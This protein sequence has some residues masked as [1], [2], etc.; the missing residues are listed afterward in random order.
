[1][2][3]NYVMYLVAMRLLADLMA[4]LSTGVATTSS[5]AQL[6]VQDTEEQSSVDTMTQG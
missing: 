6:Q 5:L 4:A 1:M 2:C 3:N